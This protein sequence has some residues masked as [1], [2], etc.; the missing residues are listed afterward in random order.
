MKYCAVD[1]LVTGAHVGKSV[2]CVAP[3]SSDREIERKA[4]FPTE[5]D[6]GRDDRP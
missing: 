4:L 5:T 2:P 3:S 1:V 6:L